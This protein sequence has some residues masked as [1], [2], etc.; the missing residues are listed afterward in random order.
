MLIK[1]IWSTMMSLVSNRYMRSY[2]ID[3]E[4]LLILKI[5]FQNSVLLSLLTMSIV[6]CRIV[7]IDFKPS[8]SNTEEMCV[9]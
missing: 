8:R 3:L 1:Y 5:A 7:E 6:I 4:T 9:A 2:T